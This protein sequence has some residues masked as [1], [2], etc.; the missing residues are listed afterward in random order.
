MEPFLKNISDII[1]D[2][3]ID[4][5]LKFPIPD[6]GPRPS[7]KPSQM[8]R[9]HLLLCLKRITSFRQLREN[10][11]HHQDWRTFSF[12]KNKNQVPSLDTLNR[13]RQKGSPLLRQINQLYMHMIFS[14]TGI[15]SAIIAVPD[16]TDI[17]AATKGYG[18]KTALVSKTVTIPE[19]FPPKMQPKDIEQK[20]Q[21]NPNGLLVTKNIRSAFSF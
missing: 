6:R 1:P 3:K 15:P 10:L 17:R 2:E 13:F 21:D 16:S 12:L 5:E 9:L 11:F 19:Y 14:I 18:K 8:Y 20:N 7:L 4:R